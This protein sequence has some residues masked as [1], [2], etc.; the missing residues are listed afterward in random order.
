M[1][2]YAVLGLAS[3]A[4]LDEA[5]AAWK[6]LAKRWHPDRV[7]DGELAAAR[8]AEINAAYDLLRADVTAAGTDGRTSLR[9]T[10]DEEELPHVPHGITIQRIRRRRAGAWLDERTRTA[11]GREL[12]GVLDEGEA[13]HLVARTATWA[14]PEARLAVTD[15]RLLWVLDDAIS[16]RVRVLR[17]R[18]VVAVEDKLAWPRRR[19]AAVRVRTREGRKLEFSE[20]APATAAAITR[21]VRAAL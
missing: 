14:S 1:D 12:L 13:V 5:A 6:R 15:R 2:P 3:D 16:H 20:L 8:M 18:D 9:G 17:Y 19:T 4:S 7:G 21:H 10:P 11:L